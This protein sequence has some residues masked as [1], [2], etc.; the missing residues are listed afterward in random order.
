MRECLLSIII[1]VYK[2]EAYIEETIRSIP[3]GE[4]IE[5]LAVNDG[6]PDRSL[7]IL[8]RLRKEET[9]LR[10]L[11]RENGGLSAARNTGIEAAKGKYLLFLDGDDVLTKDAETLLKTLR[12][13]DAEC[14]LGYYE[15]F[16]PD[17]RKERETYLTGKEGE[18]LPMSSASLYP[19]IMERE[20]D[21][22]LIACRFLPKRSF[23]RDNHLLFRKGIYHEDEEY[24]A[25]LL[26]MLS[27]VTVL[28]LPF[29]GYRREREGS[30]T[31]G[32]RQKHLQDRLL[33]LEE[34]RRVREKTAGVEA[35]R[36]LESRMS[37]LML[38]L[39]MY[40]PILPGKEREDMKKT[41]KPLRK[42]LRGGKKKTILRR[43]WKILGFRFTTEILYA[44]H[45]R[46]ERSRK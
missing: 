11:N 16:Y 3:G 7:E 21:F 22:F 35:K 46:K 41:L 6:S 26:S 36:F 25:K 37:H 14:F 18:V 19:L 45:L 24:S 2:V 40:A 17:G 15:S 43:M 23:L 33:I 8:E 32:I 1:P 9:R 42:I 31:A 4:D 28:N 13:Q 30:I 29:Y 34:L 44:L 20:D 38:G 12:E 5:I 27:S 10:I 39:M